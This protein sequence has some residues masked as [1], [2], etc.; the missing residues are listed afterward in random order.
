M[1]RRT[2]RAGLAATLLTAPLTLI[3]A[4]AS[5]AAAAAGDSDVGRQLTGQFCTNSN[6]MPKPGACIQLAYDGQ[7][8]QGYTD[9]SDR[10]LTLRPGAYWLT[11]TDNAQVHNFSL[12][13]P[14]GTDTDITGVAATPGAV[15]I[16]VNLS[17]GTWVLFCEPHRDMGMYVDLV[18]GGVG[19]VR[20]AS[21]AAQPAM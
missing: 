8:A 6:A 20:G 17:S 11:V 9:S 1:Q 2:K 12:E 4:A 18:V 16:K 19:E 7:M 13:G 10:V 21:P 14:D 5:D 15:T 3:V